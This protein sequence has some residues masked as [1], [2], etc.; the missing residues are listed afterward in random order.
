MRRF[1][2]RYRDA[3]RWS[4]GLTISGV[5]AILTLPG[6]S[7]SLGGSGVR[8]HLQNAINA[9]TTAGAGGCQRKKQQRQRQWIQPANCNGV[10]TVAAITVVID[11]TAAILVQRLDSAPGSETPTSQ[12]ILSTLNTGILYQLLIPMFIT[13]Y[14]YA[15]HQQGCFLML[16]LILTQPPEVL[17]I[18]QSTVKLSPRQGCNTSICGVV[19][20]MPCGRLH[21]RYLCFDRNKS[22]T[23]T[24]SHQQLLALTVADCS[25]ACLQHQRYLDGYG[26]AHSQAGRW[27][28]L[29]HWHLH[30]DHDC[31]YQ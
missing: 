1:S 4:A 7:A 31:G 28:L 18:L 13:R 11:P 10:I 15:A 9:I 22:G 8:R 12:R 5:P 24:N 19:L 20:W 3:M 26:L 29:W 6:C 2:F 17:Q 30:G 16:S 25:E 21:R 14:Q 23:E 27:W